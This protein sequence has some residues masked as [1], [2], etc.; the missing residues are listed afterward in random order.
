MA[1]TYSLISKSILSSAASSVTL[2]SIPNTYTDILI[3]I[4]ARDNSSAVGNNLLFQINGSTTSQS[5]RAIS[6][7]GSSAPNTYGTTPLFFTSNGN[8][9]TA[10]TFSNM[11]VYIPNYASTTIN[12]SVSVDS[13]SENNNTTAYAQLSA[14]LYASTTAIT[15]I[16]FTTNGG[17]NFLSGSSFYLYGI[18]NS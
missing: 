4:S 5:V 1:T 17:V 2:S 13:V 16:L 6:G 8:N 3:K 11:E 7:D 9:S 14:G 15:S 18:K 10:D 12:K